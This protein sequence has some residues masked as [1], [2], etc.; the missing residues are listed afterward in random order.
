[1]FIYCSLKIIE[2]ARRRILPIN[3]S[4]KKEKDSKINKE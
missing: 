1:V 2:T 4:F 3:P